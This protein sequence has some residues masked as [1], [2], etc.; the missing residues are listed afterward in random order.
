MATQPF[1]VVIA[2][3]NIESALEY[4]IDKHPLE[5]GQT[6]VGTYVEAPELVIA[7]QVIAKAVVETPMQYIDGILD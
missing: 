7:T 2:V 5:Y 6:E 1:A 3:D 4:P